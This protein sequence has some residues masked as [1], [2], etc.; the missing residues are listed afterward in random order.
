MNT[1]EVVKIRTSGQLQLP[2]VSSETPHD[3]HSV[4]QSKT[5]D[6]EIALA[7][8]KNKQNLRE[9]GGETTT[10]ALKKALFKLKTSHLFNC[11]K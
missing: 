5:N 7:T 9:L 6:D 1:N 2:L 11:Y 10:N 3:S 8:Y 4:C